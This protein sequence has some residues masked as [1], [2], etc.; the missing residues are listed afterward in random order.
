LFVEVLGS[1]QDVIARFQIQIAQ[2]MRDY[3]GTV[4][5]LLGGWPARAAFFWL[6]G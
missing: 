5:F 6:F 4:R 2:A 3:I 1:L